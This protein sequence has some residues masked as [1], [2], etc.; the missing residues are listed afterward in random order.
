MRLHQPQKRQ[1]PSRLLQK[2]LRL[3]SLVRL[4][5]F[6]PRFALKVQKAEL[7]R[8]RQRKCPRR[9]RLQSRRPESLA[10]QR[11]FWPQSVVPK[12]ERPPNLLAMHQ[13]QRRLP[14]RS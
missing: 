5:T 11:I 8:L 1:R 12:A 7:L 9:L 13:P 10:Q 3:R 6:S 2:Q 14:L 4:A